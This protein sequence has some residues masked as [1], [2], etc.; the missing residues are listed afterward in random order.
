MGRKTPQ[1]KSNRKI[2]RSLQT[3]T[4]SRLQEIRRTAKYLCTSE[5]RL[6][7]EELAIALENTKQYRELQLND[8]ISPAKKARGTI[9]EC[10]AFAK[11]LG[12]PWSDG[13]F[14][15][16]HME[17]KGWIASGKPVR[18]WRA[19]FRKWKSGKWLPSQ[20]VNGHP[21]STPHSTRHAL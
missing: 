18:D 2:S 5:A 17:E 9:E 21:K 7:I 10:H 15:F 14:F 20:K 16:N 13:E 8:A 4:K 6:L 11:E 1:C 3:V 19:G 12:M